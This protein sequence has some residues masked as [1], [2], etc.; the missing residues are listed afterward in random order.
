MAVLAVVCG[1]GGLGPPGWGAMSNLK[2]TSSRSDLYRT[3]YVRTARAHCESDSCMLSS[4]STIAQ[5]VMESQIVGESG[6]G[7]N[8]DGH[9]A[10]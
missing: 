2:G 5:L 6:K 4:S 1:R 7:S 9:V 3:R 8:E 10:L